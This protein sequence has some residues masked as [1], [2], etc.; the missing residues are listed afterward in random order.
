VKLL[1]RCNPLKIFISHAA[2]D[3]EL[4]EK[5]LDLLQLGVGVSRT[6]IFC[7]STKG[8]I[9][10]GE[11]FV[12]HILSELASADVVFSILS[13][14]YFASAFCLA[15]VGA[16]QILSS[17]KRAAFRSLLVPPAD[18]ADLKGILYGV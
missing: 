10:N 17:S 9:P 11:F 18:F 15:E 5:F 8:A 6:N 14:S 16:A 1:L 2:A 3:L 7:S 4:V 13:E 12:N